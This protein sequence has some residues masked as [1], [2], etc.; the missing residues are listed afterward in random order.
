MADFRNNQYKP[1]VINRHLLLDRWPYQ[2]Y[3][4]VP[5]QL[6]QKAANEL[7]TYAGL[8]TSYGNCAVEVVKSAPVNKEALKLSFK[9]CVH[10]AALMANQLC[11][12]EFRAQGSIL[13]FKQGHEPYGI[14]Y[15][16]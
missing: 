3:F 4:L 12:T 6:R 2:F 11:A 8:M 16:I 5:H 7:P 9:E 10:L 15:Q 14:E 13:N 1:H